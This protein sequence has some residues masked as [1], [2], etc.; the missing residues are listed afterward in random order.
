[1]QQRLSPHQPSMRRPHDATLHPRGDSDAFMKQDIYDKYRSSL[2]ELTFNSKPIITKLTMMAENLAPFAPV[3]ARAVADH[4]RVVTRTLSH[5]YICFNFF[6]F[7]Y[8]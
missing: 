3:V 5:Q 6:R 7:Q 4:W 1:M 2:Q 8:I